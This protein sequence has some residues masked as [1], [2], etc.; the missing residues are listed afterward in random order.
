[1]GRDQRPTQAPRLR[2]QQLAEGVQQ[3]VGSSQVYSC[4]LST[5]F[6]FDRFPRKAYPIGSYVERKCTSS[7]KCRV[8]LLLVIRYQERVVDRGRATCSR[9]HNLF[10]DVRWGTPPRFFLECGVEGGVGGGAGL[11]EMRSVLK[12]TE[13][14]RLPKRRFKTC[15]GQTFRPVSLNFD[16]S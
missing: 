2:V 6:E 5:S 12:R 11:C 3:L 4:V 8:R 13:T 7:V 1:M 9:A 15:S 10:W 14:F 16:F